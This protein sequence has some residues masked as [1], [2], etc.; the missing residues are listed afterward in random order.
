MIPTRRLVYNFRGSYA[1]PTGAWASTIT[2]AAPPTVQVGG[3]GMQLALTAD[4]Q[5][6]NVSLHFAD[7]LQL[8]IDDILN[9]E[10]LAAIT[11]SMGASVRGVFGVATARNDDPDAI[12]A[13]ALMS[14]V[15]N[16]VTVRTADGT[17]TRS[18]A[19]AATLGLTPKRFRFDFAAGVRTQSP[20]SQSVGGKSEIYAYASNNKNSLRRIAELTSFDMSNY[21]GGLQLFAQLQKTATTDAATLTIMEYVVELK[22][23]A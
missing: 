2:G 15:Q 5:V 19:G 23:P 13:S 7:K 11:D 16:S 3:G 9:V 4:S 18:Q 17:N 10:I 1:L 12:T 8:D 20:P 6:Q 22:L 14:V 21:S